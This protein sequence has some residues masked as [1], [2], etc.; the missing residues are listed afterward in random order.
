[1]AVLRGHTE[2]MIASKQCQGCLRVKCGGDR[3]G[4]L[5]KADLLL[6]RHLNSMRAWNDEMQRACEPQWECRI[7]NLAIVTNNN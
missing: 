1:M 6:K 7:L 4:F 3:K 5:G 2:T